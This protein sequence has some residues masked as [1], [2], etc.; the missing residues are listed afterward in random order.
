MR[1]FQVLF[2]VVIVADV[3]MVQAVQRQRGVQTY[4]PN[5]VQG[6]DAP[7]VV[8]PESIQQILVGVVVVADVGIS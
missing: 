7:A 8:V 1:I 2:G 3:G 4:P 6:G 5:A